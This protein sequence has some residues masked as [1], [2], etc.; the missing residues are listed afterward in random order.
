MTHAMPYTPPTMPMKA[1]R[2][3]RGTV[4]AIV[5][6]A[7]VNNPELPRPAMAR[8]TINTTE[9]GAAPQMTV[10][11]S[12]KRRPVRYTIFTLKREYIFPSNSWN[13]V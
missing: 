11:T 10:P 1:G 4:W 6:M 9:F 3:G 2:L 7:P 8:P 13:A 12:N 5:N